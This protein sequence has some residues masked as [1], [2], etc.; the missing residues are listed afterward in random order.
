MKDLISIWNLP[1]K[2][3]AIE[4]LPRQCSIFVT[5]RQKPKFLTSF[6]E[7]ISLTSA[8]MIPQASSETESST[9]TYSQVSVPSVCDTSWLVLEHI[10]E[11]LVKQLEI[12]EKDIG[13]KLIRVQQ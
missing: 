9:S 12:L 11:W 1:S 8:L 6:D 13:Q 2:C 10:T 5:R 7:V 4:H 3:P